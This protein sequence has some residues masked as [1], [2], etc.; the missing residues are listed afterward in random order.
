[1]QR[2]E[3]VI[4]LETAW[5]VCDRGWVRPFSGEVVPCPHATQP[6][7]VCQP[8]HTGSSPPVLPDPVPEWLSDWKSH[9]GGRPMMGQEFKKAGHKASTL[10]FNPTFIL[11][12]SILY[13]AGTQ[14]LVAMCLFFYVFPVFLVCSLSS[15]SNC[16]FM[17]NNIEWA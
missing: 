14:E 2:L 16:L 5:N 13:I 12:F 6:S 15:P 1:M 8:E 7:S 4:C 10:I 17:E 3:R 9:L 11:R